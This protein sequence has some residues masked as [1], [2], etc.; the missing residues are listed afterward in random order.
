[1]NLLLDSH[2][3]YPSI[4]NIFDIIY[5]KLGYF[6]TGIFAEKRVSTM[7]GGKVIDGGWV[8]QYVTEVFYFVGTEKRFSS[9]LYPPQC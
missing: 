4:D 6:L 3:D 1:M 2:L 7:A 9:V 5:L 8:D